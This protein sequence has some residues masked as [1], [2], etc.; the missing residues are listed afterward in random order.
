[1][2]ATILKEPL[3]KRMGRP[4]KLGGRKTTFWIEDTNAEMLAL[5]A[6]RNAIDKTAAINLLIRQTLSSMGLQEEAA[7]RVAERKQG[8]N[9][10]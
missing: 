1:M 6:E 10:D 7:R 3:I 8:N 9:D 5:F 2:E 4:R